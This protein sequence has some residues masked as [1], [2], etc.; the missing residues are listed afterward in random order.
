MVLAVDTWWLP[1]AAIEAKS[2]TWMRCAGA[3]R[4]DK[5]P[6]SLKI[7]FQGP[8]DGIDIWVADVRVSPQDTDAVI[9]HLKEMAEKVCGH[10]Y[11]ALF[12]LLHPRGLK[13]KGNAGE[14]T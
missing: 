6:Q 3:F 13:C 14:E 9:T 1:V 12:A 10:T 11:I 8:P 2:A 5:K 4:L 7:Y